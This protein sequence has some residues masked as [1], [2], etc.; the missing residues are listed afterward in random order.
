MIKN[1]NI[2]KRMAFVLFYCITM[3]LCFTAV[4]GNTLEQKNINV[5]FVVDCSNSMNFNDKSNLSGELIKLFTDTAFSDTNIG[6]VLYDDTILKSMPLVSANDTAAVR[7]IQQT[8]QSMVR[9]GN[10]DIGLALKEATGLLPQ[11]E[12]EQ[13][14]IVL[15]S[16]G[17]TD[18]NTAKTGRTLQNSYEDENTAYQNAKQSNTRIFTIAL[19]K[20]QGMDINYLQKIADNTNGQC[21]ML[22]EQSQLPDLFQEIYEKITENHVNK[23]ED[24][25]GSGAYEKQIE[26]INGFADHSAIVIH[27]KN[28]VQNI[29]TDSQNSQIAYSQHYAVIRLEQPYEERVKIQLQMAQNDSV[30]IQTIHHITVLP[31]IEPFSEDTLL[32]LPVSVKLYE[33]GTQKEMAAKELYENMTAELSVTDM[34]TGENQKIAM[35]NAQT[36]MVTSF[37]NKNPRAYRFEAVVK[38]GLYQAKTPAYEVELKNTNPYA[39][40]KE[41]I[42]VLM[43]KGVK[44]ID[45]NEYFQDDDGDTLVYQI[46]KMPHNFQAEIDK[47]ML[48]IEA[49]QNITE[50]MELYVSDGRGGVLTKTLTI[51]AMPFWIYYKNAIIGILVLFIFLACIYFGVV[52]RQPKQTPPQPQPVQAPLF[53][54][55]S[56]FSNARFEGY[57]LNTLSGNE[58]PVLNWNAS[59]IDHKKSITLAELFHILDVTEKLPEAHKIHIGAGKNGTVLFYHDTDCIVS[60]KGR[61]IP[62]GKKEVLHYEDKLYIVFEDTVTEMELRYKRKRK[63]IS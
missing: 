51:H 18:L 55:G 54:G 19:S 30:T 36:A 15:F 34:E 11:G 37:E 1:K 22:N 17:E 21:Y 10:T 57:F 46:G 60:L 2:Q 25:T 56:I 27:S 4:Y 24:V 9:R 47:N 52:K 35:G 41:K 12:Q 13:N 14:A 40:K 49:E 63:T 6:L 50:E 7:E 3:A 20:S 39:S 31:K 53:P 42:N 23:I 58:I 16:D 33:K 48:L 32:Y 62:R 28:G 38:K 26:M 5:V 61:D 45:L 44:K 8:V 43:G 59:Y 29:T